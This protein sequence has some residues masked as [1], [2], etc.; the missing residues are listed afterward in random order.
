MQVLD[1]WLADRLMK[2]RGLRPDYRTDIHG[3][4][5]WHERPKEHWEDQFHRA[6]AILRSKREEAI[7]SGH[8]VASGGRWPIQEVV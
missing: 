8:W 7:Q 1:D 6:K 4:H 3:T 5:P 2:G